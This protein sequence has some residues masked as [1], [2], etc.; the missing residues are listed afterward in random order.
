MIDLPS[1]KYYSQLVVLFSWFCNVNL[2]QF[3]ISKLLLEV[4]KM[5]FL[6]NLSLVHLWLFNVSRFLCVEGKLF[7][8]GT[9]IRYDLSPEK[10]K[11]HAILHVNRVG[12]ICHEIE[13]M[14]MKRGKKIIFK[15]N[16]EQHEEIMA[17]L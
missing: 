17:N 4:P 11:L 3:F 15:V 8:H 2:H 6:I 9:P 16:L 14:T 1:H 12:Y 7:S 10:I 5:L 13:E